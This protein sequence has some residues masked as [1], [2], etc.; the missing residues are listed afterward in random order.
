MRR[1]HRAESTATLKGALVPAK[2]DDIDTLWQQ[3]AAEASSRGFL[4]FPGAISIEAPA[5]MW[6]Q[7]KGI[8]AFLDLAKTL[9][10]QIVYLNSDR[11]TPQAV[12]DSLALALD[13]PRDVFEADTPETFFSQIGISAQP[14]VRDYLRL[15]SQH[16]GRRTSVRLEWVHDGI[17]HRFL[18]HADW[19][20][21]FL[22][23]TADVV[24]LVESATDDSNYSE[25]S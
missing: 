18:V 12:L 2:L 11:F 17:V 4:V 14:E 25:E 13:D 6:P 9:G 1:W 8:L 19:H 15:A 7:E 21:P 16:Y 10:K 3:A 22:D 24:D 5:A 23:K 20:M